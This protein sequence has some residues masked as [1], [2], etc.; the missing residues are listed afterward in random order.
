MAYIRDKREERTGYQ[1]GTQL[2]DCTDF[3]NDFVMVYRYDSSMLERIKGYR[4]AGYVIHFMTGISWGAY[5]EYLDGSFDGQKHWDEAQVDRYGNQIDH[6]RLV[7][8]MCPSVAFAD[9]I[10]EQLKPVVDAGVEAIHVEEPE[11]WDRAGYSEAFKREFEIYYRKPWKAPHLSCEAH[12][13]CAKLKAYLYARTISRV[14]AAIKEY[15]FRKYGRAV[16]F[17]VPTHSLINY[18]QWKIVSPEGKL[19]DIEG[20]DGCIAQ[21]WTGTSR[22]KN[23]YNGE[24][25]ERT[26]ETAFLEYGVMQELVAGSGKKM[27]FLHDPIEDNPAFDWNDYRKNYFMTVVASLLQ[28][29]VNI[30]EICPWP[31]RVFTD[32]YPRGAEDATYIP[33]EYA[34]LL[35]NTFQTLGD[36]EISP[37]PEGVKVGILVADSQLWQRDCIGGADARVGTVLSDTEEDIK[38]YKEKLFTGKDPSLAPKFAASSGLPGFYS[39][40]LPLLKGGIPLRP[41]LLDNTRRYNGYLDGYD[42][43]VLSYEFMKPEYPDVNNVIAQ[44]VRKGGTLIYVGDGSDPY[45]KITSWW[46]GTYPTAAEHLFAMLGTEEP[47]SGVIYDIGRGR[48]CFIDKDPCVFCYDEAGGDE[49]RAVFK[50]AASKAG[51]DVSF[52]NTLTLDRGPYKVIGVMDEAPVGGAH[53]EKGLFADMFT[54]D[55][56][57]I[58]GKTVAPGENALLFDFDRIKDEN[59][60]VIGTSMRVYSLEQS[61]RAVTVRLRGATLR[62]AHLRLRLPGK[63]VAARAR[64]PVE[65]TNDERS[66]TTLFSFESDGGEIEIVIETEQ[67]A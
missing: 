38:E 62:H 35:N 27:W 23:W 25:R 29:A 41:V 42:V 9:F 12:Y 33:D 40:A 39:L 43:L 56:R 50:A 14:S 7:P 32:K 34:T 51:F 48:F 24:F 60:R 19:A 31:T 44:W 26:F 1:N 45:H 21:V 63:T 59:L 16:R 67:G 53:E 10:T 6:G 20:V 3:N 64:M 37:A 65:F 57:I 5:L 4:D 49:M 61:G 58:D 36:I 11:F 17:Y 28:P 55:F 22:E 15:S 30:Y 47:E 46:T 18:T 54:P 52:T 13:E 66:R 2:L 8:Y